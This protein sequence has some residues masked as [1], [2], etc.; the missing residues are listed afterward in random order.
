MML[1]FPSPLFHMSRAR[2]S[3][4]VPSQCQ[5]R[6]RAS[7]QRSIR[8]PPQY[9]CIEPRIVCFRTMAADG[10][11]LNAALF[12][13]QHGRAYFGLEAT[14]SRIKSWHNA[15]LITMT[16]FGEPYTHE[17]DKEGWLFDRQV[18]HVFLFF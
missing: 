6:L 10:T 18:V 13:F 5:L 3:S 9:R 11:I 1:A 16:A 15:G 8:L 7:T 4:E 12:S 17:E 14:F 2:Q